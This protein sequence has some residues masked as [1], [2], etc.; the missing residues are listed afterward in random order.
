MAVQSFMQSF[1]SIR[2][3][4]FSVQCTHFCALLSF[5]LSFSCLN[6]IMGRQD[7][8]RFNIA[9]HLTRGWRRLP[10]NKKFLIAYTVYLALSLFR[11]SPSAALSFQFSLH[12]SQNRIFM[13]RQQSKCIKASENRS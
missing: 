13:K 9:K 4:S 2:S 1:V 8:F 7:R 5:I 12:A 10:E 11:S 6:D 3:L